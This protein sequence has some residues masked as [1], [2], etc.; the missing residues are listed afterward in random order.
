MLAVAVPL[1]V[2]GRVGLLLAIGVFASIWLMLSALIDVAGFVWKRHNLRGYPRGLLGMNIAHFGI[3]VFVLGVAITYAFGVEKDVGMKTGDVLELSG[4]SFELKSL[5]DVN[6]PN[7]TAVQAE[8]V[9]REG[10]RVIATLNPQKR[11]YRVQKNPMTEAAIHAR[12]SRDL[13]VALGEPLGGDT[14]SLR[15]Q[16]KPMIRLI[17]LGALLMAAGGLVSVSDLR[18]RARR[19]S[20]V[21]A[22]ATEAAAS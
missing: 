5:S 14:W 9:I 12:L 6:G 3:G 21:P 11:V 4:Y 10:S 15:I 2:Y 13:F 7:Y 20:E 19:R 1:F 8:V 16:Y 22:G 18:Y 17:W